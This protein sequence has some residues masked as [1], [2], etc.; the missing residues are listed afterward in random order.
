MK[1]LI[2]E[3]NKCA[4]RQ[5]ANQVMAQTRPTKISAKHN[6]LILWVATQR[7]R[8]LNWLFKM[9]KVLCANALMLI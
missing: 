2:G 4:C 6:F 3:F 1:K 5:H 8:H 7:S 9:K